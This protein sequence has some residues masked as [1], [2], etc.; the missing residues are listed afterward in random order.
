[1]F[2]AFVLIILFILLG[3]LVGVYS[4]FAPFTQNIGDVIDFNSAYYGALA[5]IER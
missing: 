1:M 3:V 5:G 2:I 4:I